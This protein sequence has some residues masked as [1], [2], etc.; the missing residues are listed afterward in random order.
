MAKLRHS[1]IVKLLG[2][3]DEPGRLGIVAEWLSGGTLWDA[4]HS[5]EARLSAKTS[6]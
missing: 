5:P 2:I 6:L 1:G 4:I 3:I